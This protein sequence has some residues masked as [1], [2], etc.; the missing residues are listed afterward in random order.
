M[1]VQFVSF[2]SALP[3]AKV[4]EVAMNRIEEFRAL[5]GLLQKTYVKLPEPNRY[6]GIYLWDSVESMKAFRE[7]QLAATIPSAYKVVG[8]PK[9]EIM[10]TLFLLRETEQIAKAS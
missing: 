9:I 2:E 3:E 4:R 10:D 8:A 7:S 1:I 6:G 5:P